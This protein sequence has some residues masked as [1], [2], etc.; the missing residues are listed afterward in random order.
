[1]AD[2]KNPLVLAAL[3]AKIGDWTY[4][5]TYMN[6]TDIANRIKRAQQFY[7]SKTL[8]DLLQRAIMEKRPHEIADYLFK[9]PQRFLNALVIG[10][11]GGDPKWTEV[12]IEKV[13][14]FKYEIPNDLKGTI[15]FLILDGDEQLFP[16]DGQHR[17][18]GIKIA[19]EQHPELGKEDVCVILVRGISAGSKKEDPK[20]FERTRRL[21]TTLNRYA[22]PVNMRDII[23]LDEDDVMAITTRNLVEN[24]ALFREKTSTTLQYSINKADKTSFTSIRALYDGLNVYHKDCSSSK[25]RDFLKLYPGPEQEKEYYENSI[26]LW[27]TLCD[28]F[29]PLNELKD[30]DPEENIASKYR[31]SDDNEHLLFRPIGLLIVLQVISLLINKYTLS[32]YDSIE[33]ISHVPMDLREEPWVNILWNPMNQTILSR[34]KVTARILLYYAVGGDLSHMRTNV[35]KLKE[36]IAAIQNR[37]ISE[38]RIRKYV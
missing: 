25:W 31:N 24:N 6:M 5:I 35:S 17:I 30:S 22:K 29:P 32:L 14:P 34:N 28:F 2:K 10:T 1:M 9:Q 12:S 36:R 11:Y 21:F 38:I 8:Q 15:G 26:V 37:E 7:T 20:G 18:E 4:Y 16:I 3:R 23:A 27:D 13:L 19:V 33:K